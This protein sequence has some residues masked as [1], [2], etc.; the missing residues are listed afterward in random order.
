MYLHMYVIVSWKHIKGGGGE[1][2]NYKLEVGS[3]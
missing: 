1:L 3:S 2:P